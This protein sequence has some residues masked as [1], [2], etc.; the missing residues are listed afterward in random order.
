[1][2][3]LREDPIAFTGLKP[4]QA[5]CARDSL[6]AHVDAELRAAVKDCDKEKASGTPDL[7]ITTQ[8]QV[9]K[10]NCVHILFM[11]QCYYLAA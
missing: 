11:M 4:T 8:P 5:K 10:N 6:L 3:T 2:T 1:M 9:R 7:K